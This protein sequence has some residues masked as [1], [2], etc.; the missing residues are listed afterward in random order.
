[1]KRI[2][3]AILILAVLLIVSCGSGAS[4]TLKSIRSSNIPA[5]VL[6]GDIVSY[7]EQI[8]YYTDGAPDEYT[9]TYELSDK[10]G[11]GY[12]I[13]EHVGSYIMCAIDG[14]V[15]IFDGSDWFTVI[16][17]NNSTSYYKFISD[18]LT[19]ECQLDAAGFYQVYANISDEVTT[20]EYRAEITPQL[21]SSVY[22][23]SINEQ[24]LLCATY[25]L[26]RDN[27]IIDVLYEAL[28]PSGER[29]KLMKREY[30]Y[31]TDKATIGD[32]LPINTDVTRT[33]TVINGEKELK[34]TVPQG[35]RVS[36]DPG[37]VDEQ[38]YVQSENVPYDPYAYAD[39]T[40]DLTLYAVQGNSD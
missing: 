6:S 22:A 4:V 14:E 36:P 25:N 20:V 17:T 5:A 1:M 9:I 11:A 29:T 21:S 2:I 32:D 19:S 37:T 39:L 30:T 35:V 23:F 27:K 28:S 18:Y 16:F 38:Y 3:C 24:D 15:Y 33:V 13:S 34:F 12:N 8:V 10:A 7:T 31:N 26:K 40:G